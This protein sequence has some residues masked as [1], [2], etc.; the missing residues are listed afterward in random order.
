[1][2]LTLHLLFLFRLAPSASKSSFASAAS[3]IILESNLLPEACA[4]LLAEFPTSLSSS[5]VQQHLEDGPLRSLLHSDPFR[6]CQ[7]LWRRRAKKGGANMYS[8]KQISWLYASAADL[9]RDAPQVFDTFQE[10]HDLQEALSHLREAWKIRRR[11]A[12]QQRKAE[13]IQLRRRQHQVR[14]EAVLAPTQRKVPRRTLLSN[15]TDYDQDLEDDFFSELIEQVRLPTFT[16]EEYYE[17]DEEDEDDDE[18]VDAGL[19]TAPIYSKR[20][21]LRELRGVRL[22]RSNNIVGGTLSLSD[23]TLC[24]RLSVKPEL[25]LEQMDGLKN[26]VWFSYSAAGQPWSSREGFSSMRISTVVVKEPQCPIEELQVTP[27]DEVSHK[28][29]QR[30]LERLWQEHAPHKDPVLHSFQ[31]VPFPHCNV[32]DLQV[33][34]MDVLHKKRTHKARRLDRYDPALR[35]VGCVVLQTPVCDLTNLR[36]RPLDEVVDRR[37][38]SVKIVTQPASHQ[39]SGTS[40]PSGRSSWADSLLR[41]RSLQEETGVL[42]EEEWTA[43]GDV[44][45][46]D[47]NANHVL[48]ASQEGTAHSHDTLKTTEAIVSSALR[49]D[50]MTSFHPFDVSRAAAGMWREPED[51]MDDDITDDSTKNHVQPRPAE[52]HGEASRVIHGHGL[53]ATHVQAFRESST[54]A[55][56]ELHKS[57]G[58]EIEVA[59]VEVSRRARASEKRRKSQKDGDADDK[60]RYAPLPDET[61]TSTVVF[62]RMSQSSSVGVVEEVEDMESLWITNTKHS[63]HDVDDPFDDNVD[64]ETSAFF[65]QA[66]LE[67][68]LDVEGELHRIEAQLRDVRHELDRLKKARIGRE[69]PEFLNARDISILRN[70]CDWSMMID[71]FESIDGVEMLWHSFRDAGESSDDDDQLLGVELELLREFNAADAFAR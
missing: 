59:V 36:E 56:S 31:Q 29:Y 1:M 15:I 54:N 60:P 40:P 27:I 12:R 18:E 45:V 4:A 42:D 32:G 46:D 5:S 28:R 14:Q 51:D 16:L 67:V 9:N 37:L 11:E 30:A 17:D 39:P 41:R 63:Q 10:L 69:S 53:D 71:D 65:G 7:T 57:A 3:A 47:Q 61:A 20:E 13:R 64:D 43:D 68:N 38:R 70:G 35:V 48:V 24:Y 22:A 44:V 25:D 19:P 49:T 50:R 58:E 55:P 8:S 23:P 26:A 2:R 33:M 62:T 66:S 21:L 52:S 6:R 34:A